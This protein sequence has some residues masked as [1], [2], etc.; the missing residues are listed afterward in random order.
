M[1]KLYFCDFW[2]GF[3]PSQNLLKDLIKL[4]LRTDIHVC[5]Q[6]EASEA[7]LVLC[8][9][10]GT[11][12]QRYS[13]IPRLV[14]IGE[15]LRPDYSQYEYSFSF[16]A[17]GYGGKNL[18]FPLWLWSF[19]WFENNP[20]A[21][22]RRSYEFLVEG[23][24]PSSF[25]ARHRK[26]VALIGNPTKWRLEHLRKINKV[27][28]IEAFGTAFS[29]PLAGGHKEKLLL[30]T[31]YQYHYCCENSIFPGYI[32][33]KI[34]DAKLAGCIPVYHSGNNVDNELN[35]RAIVDLAAID[36]DQFPGEEPIL[37]SD[38]LMKA[39][40]PLFNIPF[41]IGTLVASAAELCARALSVKP[42]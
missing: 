39:S 33:E 13:R 32:T 34:I 40:E 7:D 1:I 4:A 25:M 16:D 21:H 11:E 6:S 2:P 5:H 37:G 26:C 31:N 19:D 29:R 20:K 41:S 17:E 38:S 28:P 22:S 12:K 35:L 23:Y 27:L 14:Y 42:C 18:R 36:S 8:S 15:N 24:V 9:V 30:L 10:F 3:N